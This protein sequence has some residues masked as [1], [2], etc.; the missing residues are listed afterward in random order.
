MTPGAGAILAVDMPQTGTALATSPRTRAR[1]REARLEL[2]AATA[3]ILSYL[4]LWQ[5]TFPGDVLVCLAL[6]LA[7][8]IRGHLRRGESPRELGFRL[9][10]AGQS[11]RIV[12]GYVGPLIVLVIATGIA[13]DLTRE[14]PIERLAA[15][16]FLTPV[17]GV[18]QQYALLGFYYRRIEEALPGRR[19]ALPAT[20]STFAVF[21]APDPAI[22]VVSFLLG[23][24]ACWLYRR[25][26]NLWVLGVAHGVLSLTIAMFLAEL[27]PLGLKVG[28]RALP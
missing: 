15:R 16:L 23:A 13:W 22:I 9:D 28:L 1:A 4:W 14:P 24:A 7:L 18:V 21:H 19:L 20:A 5:R 3:L 27:L 10:N 17:F 2:T 12:L 8:A 26:G 11:A 6:F 25:A